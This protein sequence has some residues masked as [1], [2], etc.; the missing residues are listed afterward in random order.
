MANVPP[1][2]S[3]ESTGDISLSA[4]LGKI[5]LDALSV[6]ISSELSTDISSTGTV[7]VTGD[8]ITLN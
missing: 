3:I 5:S 4:P 1:G 8:L 2:V 6:E 7:G